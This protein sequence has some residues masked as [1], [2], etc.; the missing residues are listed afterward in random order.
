MSLKHKHIVVISCPRVLQVKAACSVS[1][2]EFKTL[3]LWTYL[4]TTGSFVHESHMNFEQK[5]ASY[6]DILIYFLIIVV[7]ILRHHHVFFSKMVMSC[8]HTAHRVPLLSI[9]NGRMNPA[10]SWIM[11]FIIDLILMQTESFFR[12]PMT[13]YNAPQT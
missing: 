9:P 12:F 2:V 13:V 3:G 10:R 1:S 5:L 8:H 7:L 6:Y 11:P 4:K